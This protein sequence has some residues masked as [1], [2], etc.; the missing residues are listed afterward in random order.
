MKLKEHPKCC[1]VHHFQDKNSCTCLCH[2]G[3]MRYAQQ[4]EIAAI[5]GDEN[6]ELFEKHAKM[7]IIKDKEKAGH[8]QAEITYQTYRSIITGTDRRFK[9]IPEWFGF[10][11]KSTVHKSTVIVGTWEA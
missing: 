10:L 7:L 11:S 6:Y 5:P 8:A 2:H 1:M 9:Y 3:T 4:L